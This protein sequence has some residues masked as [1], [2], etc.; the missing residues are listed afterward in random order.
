VEIEE[1]TLV[2]RPCLPDTDFDYGR[3]TFQCVGQFVEGADEGGDADSK[4]TFRCHW[5]PKPSLCL[6]SWAQEKM[7]LLFACDEAAANQRFLLRHGRWRSASAPVCVS[8]KA[9]HATDWK[10]G[11]AGTDDCTGLAGSEVHLLDWVPPPFPPGEAPLPSPPALPPPPFPPPSPSPPE[12]HMNGGKCR[13]MLR[14]KTHLFRRMWAAEAWAKMDSGPACWAIKRD[15]STVGQEPET[16]FDETRTGAHCNSNWYEGNVN[17]VLGRPTAVMPRYLNMSRPAPALLGFDET[18]DEYCH[19]EA[20]L[21]NTTWSPIGWKHAENCIRANLNILALYG[22]RVPYNICRNLEWMTC[23]ARG[24]LPGQQGLANVKFAKKPSVLYPHGFTGKPIDS[25]CGWVPWNKPTGGVYG[26]ATDD[27]FY[28]EVCLFHEICENGY[29]I[30]NLDVGTDFT[31]RFSERG[32]RELQRIL[33]SP[34]EE[35]EDSTQCKK[36]HLC[37]EHDNGE[38][39][40]EV[41]VR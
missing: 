10:K 11:L 4:H 22:D 27:I 15:A 17:P 2:W 9:W 37:P 1:S 20:K 26:Y 16:Y 29:D 18:I 8:S 19:E 13:A 25:C 38:G 39:E 41:T 7:L 14:D 36:S 6:D 30:F 32:F 28:L 12:T 21:L 24:W 33:L 34:W 3:Q 40:F 23:A 35:P 5:G 31:C